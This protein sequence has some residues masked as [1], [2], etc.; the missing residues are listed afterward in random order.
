[1]TADQNSIFTALKP[2]YSSASPDGIAA[3]ITA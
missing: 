3:A 2:A 1:M